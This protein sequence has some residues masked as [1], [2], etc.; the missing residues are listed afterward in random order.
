VFDAVSGR[1]ARREPT[2]VV[3]ETGGLFYEV[4]VPT[5]TSESLEAEE[6]VFLFLHD[7]IQNDRI[8]LYGFA[9]ER[10][11]VLFRMLLAVGGVGPAT[12]L[13]VLSRCGCDR[14]VE[15]VRNEEPRMLVAVRG[16]GRKTAERI[17]LELKERVEKVGVG[18]EVAMAEDAVVALVSLGYGRREAEAAVARAVKKVGGDAPLEEV[19]REALH[20]R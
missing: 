9:T 12:A 17:V 10:E 19:V 2:R 7:V 5:T 4:L 13:L 18:A 11:R 1:L 8:T 14:L 15:A 6:D 3:V 16:I 20:A